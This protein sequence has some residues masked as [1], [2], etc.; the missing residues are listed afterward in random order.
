LVLIVL[1][2]DRPALLRRV[3]QKFEPESGV[4]TLLCAKEP[5]PG[6]R[7]T[8]KYGTWRSIVAGGD[9]E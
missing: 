9:G 4:E 2:L 1:I 3:K 7:N 8:L 6:R 5:S